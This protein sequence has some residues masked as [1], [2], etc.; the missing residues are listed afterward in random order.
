MSPLFPTRWRS[1]PS[2]LALQ[3]YLLVCLAIELI[4]S[5]AAV[6]GA[7]IQT[8]HGIDVESERS[9]IE[10]VPLP[11]PESLAGA[12]PPLTLADLEEMALANNPTL[13][14]AWARVNAARGRQVQSGLYPNPMI[15]YTGQDMGEDGTAG[16]QGGYVS[17]Q[18]ITGKKL[19]LNRAIGSREVREQR[20]LFD[21]QELRVLSD[22]RLRYYDALAAQ[23][24]VELT[25]ELSKVSAQ[26]AD[27]SRQLREAGQIADSDLLQAEIESE[28]AQ[29]LATNAT[30]ERQE[31]WRRLSAVVGVPAMAPS[32][33]VGAL[34]GELPSYEWAE[35]YIAVLGQ[36]PQ[37]AAAIARIERARIAIARA[38]K[39]NVPD[40][41]V[42]TMVTHMNQTG[43]DVVGVQAGIP[44]PVLNQNQ[45]NIMAAQA[46]LTAAANDLRRIELDLQD[47]LAMAYRRYANARQQVDRYRNEILPRADRSIALLGEGYRAGQTDF[48]PLLTSQRTYIRVNIAYVDALLELQQA[49]TLIEGQ[50]L[51]DSLQAD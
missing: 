3:T 30:N 48:L 22:V 33:L 9:A 21:A 45:G 38:R 46:E 29:I 24:R 13:T 7:P 35:V 34:D 19:Q 16:Q 1:R 44:I 51:S 39:E 27:N 40:V 49:A 8:A 26:L 47:R 28:E 20:F 12:C 32:P 50:L 23:R 41:S 6:M 43:D 17:Q 36:H 2:S 18:F 14:V 4:V 5:A 11:Q 25:A 42:M 31:A 10:L 15:G 37:L